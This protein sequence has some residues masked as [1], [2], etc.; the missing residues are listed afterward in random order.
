MGSAPPDFRATVCRDGSVRLVDWGPWLTAGGP[1]FTLLAA[2][3]RA[4]FGIAD[5]T[6]IRDADGIAHELV[7]EFRAGGGRAHRKGLCAWASAV[8]YRRVWLRGELAELEPEPGGTAETR[9]TGCRA[10]FVEAG[11]RFWDVVRRRGAFPTVCVLCGSDLPQWK[12]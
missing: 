10:R 4:G 1:L 11:P 3:G 5:L 8:G 2:R 9:C 6:V 7:A 12:A